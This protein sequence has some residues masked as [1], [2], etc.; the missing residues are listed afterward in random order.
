MLSA[1]PE[2]IRGPNYW[3][4]AASRQLCLTEADTQTLLDLARRSVTLALEGRLPLQPVVEHYPASL[5]KMGATFVTLRIGQKVL[6]RAGTV[7]AS[8]PLVSD[9][10]HN[11][12]EVGSHVAVG[13]PEADAPETGLPESDLTVGVQIVS[14]VCYL[15]ARSLQDVLAELEVGSDGVLLQHGNRH[16][17]FTP[18]LWQQWPDPTVFFRALQLKAGLDPQEWP[19]GL[20]VATYRVESL[21]E[22]RVIVRGTRG[23]PKAR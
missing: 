10:C 14:P 23:S 8:V 6:S 17:T 1:H 20:S 18:E 2:T 22:T 11:A 13:L 19:A 5:Q 21:P 16:A 7:L 4:P 3:F 12:F 15:T 9:V